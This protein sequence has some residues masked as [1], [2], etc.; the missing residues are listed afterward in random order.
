MTVDLIEMV[1]EAKDALTVRRVFGDP[2]EK[3]G[4]TVIPAARV[5]GGAGGGTQKDGKNDSVGTGFGLS[6]KPAGVF[7]IRDGDVAWRPAIDV[8]RV[9]LGGQLFGLAALLTVRSILKSRAKVR[10]LEA[11]ALS[12]R[13]REGTVRSRRRG[14]LPTAY[15]PLLEDLL[16]VRGTHGHHPAPPSG[17]RR[18]RAAR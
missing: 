15:L 14:R 17:R 7:V 1:E 12:S 13:S 4:V 16:A 11:S 10:A 18:G 5:Q 9:I 8:N 3:D 2:F 6:A